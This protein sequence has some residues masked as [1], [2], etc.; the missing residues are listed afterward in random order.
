MEDNLEQ[1]M[2][3]SEKEIGDDSGVY[4]S[5]NDYEVIETVARVLQDRCAPIMREVMLEGMDTI[6]EIIRNKEYYSGSKP[7]MTRIEAK[8]DKLLERE[9]GDTENGVLAE[10]KRMYLI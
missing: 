1:P 2:V 7:Q 10:I 9:T 8:L 3:E 5:V 6:R 4:N